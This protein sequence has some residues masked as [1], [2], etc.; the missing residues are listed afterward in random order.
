MYARVHV[1]THTHSPWS[2]GQ[3]SGAGSTTES[4]TTKVNCTTHKPS[5]R[6]A[7][8]GASYAISCRGV[9]GPGDRMQNAVGWLPCGKPREE[10]KSPVPRV[11]ESPLSSVAMPRGHCPPWRVI[12]W[13]AADRAAP[14]QRGRGHE[15]GSLQ[16][17]GELTARAT[18]VRGPGRVGGRER[19]FLPRGPKME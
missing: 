11:N 9:S 15:P 13:S 1:H 8:R 10:T 6:R 18:S 19:H 7:A 17:A 3:S 14:P 4:Q 5:G 16:A 12:L 2:H